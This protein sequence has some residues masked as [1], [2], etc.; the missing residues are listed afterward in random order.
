MHEFWTFSTSKKAYTRSQ[1]YTN[2]V[3]DKL[4]ILAFEVMLLLLL[5]LLSFDVFVPI[6][7]QSNSGQL[8]CPN[9]HEC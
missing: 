8:V 4:G 3:I 7:A 6:V 5:L 9:I 1:N 2:M